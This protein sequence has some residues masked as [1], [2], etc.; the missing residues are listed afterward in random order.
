MFRPPL[1]AL[2]GA[3]R[4][5]ILGTGGVPVYCARQARMS[6]VPV[7]VSEPE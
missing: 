4:A 7:G 1:E 5:G 3:K 6:G 2:A